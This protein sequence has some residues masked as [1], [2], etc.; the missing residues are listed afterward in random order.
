MAKDLVSVEQVSA[1]AKQTMEQVSGAMD[2]YFDFLQKT[3]SSSPS[4]GTE[5]GE[6][7]KSVAEQNIS[8]ARDYI[9]KLSQSKDLQD[10]MRI[11]S[12]FMQ[13]QLSQFGEQ[14]KTLSDAYTKAAADAAKTTIFKTSF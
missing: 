1:I 10:M 8:A 13:K 6:K 3:I 4:G 14:A 12:E 9:H 7:L 5:F 11:Q 2:T